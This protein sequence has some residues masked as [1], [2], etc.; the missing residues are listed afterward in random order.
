[1]LLTARQTRH[2]ARKIAFRVL[3]GAML[4]PDNYDKFLRLVIMEAATGQRP[5]SLTQP[6]LDA[7]MAK[8]RTLLPEADP[9]WFADRGRD[10]FNALLGA[11]RSKMRGFDNDTIDEVISTVATSD[12]LRRNVGKKNSKAIAAG[13]GG[14]KKAI[15]NL[16][17]LGKSRAKD[18]I[19]DLHGEEGL[20]TDE[21][22][23]A[24]DLPATAFPWKAP[25]GGSGAEKWIELVEDVIIG[26]PTIMRVLKAMVRKLPDGLP[27]QIMEMWTDDPAQDNRT[28]G[29]ALESSSSN[30]SAYVGQIKKKTF[31][32]LLAQRAV[33]QYIE[34][35]VEA[36]G[37]RYAALKRASVPLASR[38]AARWLAARPV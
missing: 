2:L 15:E 33:M 20:P 18:Y 36:R 4:S 32:A 28:I 7:G 1:M 5:M 16:T 31:E 19:R 13:S 26:D 17:T 24:L 3:F 11:V 27:K 12:D 38:V 37:G 25:S 29:M 22:G 23:E 6:T 35:K 9:R 21:E 10:F 34:A 14:Y 8:A 30:P